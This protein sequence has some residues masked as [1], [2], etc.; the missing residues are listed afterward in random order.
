MYLRSSLR[1][2]RTCSIVSRSRTVTVP[3]L[4]GVEIDA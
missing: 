3:S 1:W 4:I 2:M